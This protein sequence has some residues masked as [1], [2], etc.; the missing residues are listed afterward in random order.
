MQDQESFVQRLRRRDPEAWAM[1]YE[2]C[3]PKVYRYIALRVGGQS[4]AEDL[5]EQ[6]FLKALESSGSLKWRGAPASAWLFRIARNRVI[7][8]WRTDKS[9]VMVP[10]SDSLMDD[11]ADPE[12][13][14]ET[15]SAMRQ[16][17]E[18]LGQLTRAQRDVIELRFAAG[19]ST[20]E[21]AQVL[22]KSQG[23]VK[24]MQHSALVALRKRLA[25][26][27]DHEE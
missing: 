19:L 13:A 17:V 14:A 24:V 8:Y 20:A 11:T 1:L 26:W 3:F 15:N 10:L 9:K 4:E 5:A 22:G 18:A 21:V 6:V 27:S 16:V 23:A 2:E 12:T 25:G 7:D